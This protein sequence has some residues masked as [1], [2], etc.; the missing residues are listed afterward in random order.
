MNDH[1]SLKTRSGSATIEPDV[2]IVN[3]VALSNGGRT[4]TP[5][6]QAPWRED[7]HVQQDGNIIPVERRLAGSF[8]CAPFAATDDPAIPLHGWSANSPWQLRATTEQ[9]A[10]LELQHRIHGASLAWRVSLVDDA[11]LLY[12]EH[13]F[14]GGTGGVPVA[15]HP[16]VHCRGKARIFHSPKRCALTPARPLEPT[17]RLAYPARSD[18]PGRFPAKNGGTLDLTSLPMAEAHEDFAV[19]VE[20]QGH[21]LGWTAILREAEN[22][23]VFFLKLAKAMPITM[24]WYSNGGR[25]YS[26]WNGRHTGVIGIEDGCSPGGDGQ[27]ASL[28][29]NA[30]AREGVPTAIPLRHGLTTRMAHVTGAVARPDGCTGI[31]NIAISGDQLTLSLAPQG[32]L[33]LPF[34]AGFFQE[35]AVWPL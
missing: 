1:I 26:P 32:E 6:H 33:T 14:N 22:D 29:D 18:E 20:A 3:Q 12:Q 35:P 9:A 31:A 8:F 27:R 24:L 5:L 34:R 4:I 28:G 23:I 17:S 25:N 30:V 7:P 19:L 13:W 10:T 15:H 16:M 21:E 2:G 11:P